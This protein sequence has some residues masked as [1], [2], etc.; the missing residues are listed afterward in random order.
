MEVLISFYKDRED[1]KEE[2][3]EFRKKKP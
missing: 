2:N 3:G 1:E